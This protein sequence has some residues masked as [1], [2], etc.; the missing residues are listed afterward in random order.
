[1]RTASQLQSLEL[2]RNE[3]GSLSTGQLSRIF[4]QSHSLTALD[5]SFN[6]LGL[7]GIHGVSHVMSA[8]PLL[9]VLKLNGNGMGDEGCVEILGQI[10]E[11]GLSVT[12]L[13]MASNGLTRAGGMALADLLR[14]N[15]TIT[16]VDVR[17]NE[18]GREAGEKLLTVL[19]PDAHPTLT[20]IDGLALAWLA[21]CSSETT[22]NLTGMG[23]GVHDGVIIGGLLACLPGS[24]LRNV[25]ASGNCLCEVGAAHLLEGLPAALIETLDLS[26]NRIGEG[27][28]GK[29]L[30]T[31]VLPRFQRL[32]N[33]RLNCNNLGSPNGIAI[34]EGLLHTM[35][36]LTALDLRSNNLGDAAGTALAAASSPLTSLDLNDNAELG[37][38]TA[39]ALLVAMKASTS[40]LRIVCGIA[41]DQLSGSGNGSSCLPASRARGAATTPR[42]STS[43]PRARGANARGLGKPASRA[44]ESSPRVSRGAEPKAKAASLLPANPK[45]HDAVVN[46]TTLASFGHL[47]G[48]LVG[49]LFKVHGAPSASCLLLPPSHTSEDG[50]RAL[51]ALLCDRFDEMAPAC[52]AFG[53]IDRSRPI[54]YDLAARPVLM[55]CSRK[56]IKMSS[57]L[58]GWTGQARSTFEAVTRWM[59]PSQS[60]QGATTSSTTVAVAPAK[61]ILTKGASTRSAPSPDVAEAMHSMNLRASSRFT[62]VQQSN[63]SLIDLAMAQADQIDQDEQ[64]HE[65]AKQLRDLLLTVAVRLLKS[66]WDSI[67]QAETNLALFREKLHKVIKQR[68]RQEEQQRDLEQAIYAARFWHETVSIEEKAVRRV[69]DHAAAFLERHSANGLGSSDELPYSDAKGLMDAK[70]RQRILAKPRA[71]KQTLIVIGEQKLEIDCTICLSRLKSPA[72]LAGC[73]HMCCQHHS[74]TFENNYQ[75][76][77]VT[78]VRSPATHVRYCK[79]CIEKW[80]K[81]KIAKLETPNCPQCRKDTQLDDVVLV[82]SCSAA[83]VLDDQRRVLSEAEAKLDGVVP[84]AGL[85]AK[86]A[87]A[88]SAVQ[89]AEGALEKWLHDPVRLVAEVERVAEEARLAGKLREAE[90]SRPPYLAIMQHVTDMAVELEAL[91]KWKQLE[92]SQ[93]RLAEQ[94]DR[95]SRRRQALEWL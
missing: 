35:P 19:R 15:A 92:T 48:V 17:G 50:L 39:R 27:G 52:V 34:A 40:V 70:S 74:N 33:L 80:I 71:D 7:N 21:A 23:L 24:T 66:R 82:K 86:L 3:L 75:Q 68:R 81:D 26:G 9:R 12:T 95:W 4:R 57:S 53:P 54:G 58:Q 41:I 29:R 76:P 25:Q 46:L 79:Q 37:E 89:K 38:A 6:G 62:F 65:A 51:L 56:A 43:T 64:R 2:S 88:W 14:D 49:S 5:V 32:A 85:K 13:E 31:H 47:E 30:I 44:A 45:G 59:H 36:S 42:A 28:G 18:L 16:C 22:L 72:I 10:R 8:A 11:C 87:S 90:S 20:H 60:S 55:A 84:I 63:K 69:R 94:C 61:R 1:M 83:D 78:P 91:P 77:C 73:T 93:D 67:E